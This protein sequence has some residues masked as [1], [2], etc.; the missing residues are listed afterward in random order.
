MT[1]PHPLSRTRRRQRLDAGTRDLACWAKALG[2]PAR[3]AILRFLATRR[4]CFC[5]QIVEH[6]PLAQSTVSQHLRE[7]RDAG[8]IRGTVDGVRVCYCLAP[9]TVTR[10]RAAFGEMFAQ[11][12]A[13]AAASCTRGGM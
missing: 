2:H 8:L 4:T 5:G 1:T 10:M 13:A 6:L 9:E 3:I 7:L 12:E 11:L